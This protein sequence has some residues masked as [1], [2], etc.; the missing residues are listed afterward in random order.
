MTATPY[1]QSGVDATHI[2]NV[3][4]FDPDHPGGELHVPAQRDGGGGS[5]VTDILR[6][7][8][9][10]YGIPVYNQ[11]LHL[12]DSTDS[13]GKNTESIN[14]KIDGR[15]KDTDLI[16]DG[17]TILLIESTL[18]AVPSFK[19]VRF[20]S[21]DDHSWCSKISHS[22]DGN[23]LCMVETNHFDNNVII[24]VYD[25]GTE[26]FVLNYPCDLPMTKELEY[27][28]LSADGKRLLIVVSDVNTPTK[29]WDSTA[30][31][32][33]LETGKV[34]QFDP[35]TN[36]SSACL[37]SNGE[38]LAMA[39]NT[40]DS[41]AVLVYQ[42]DNRGLIYTLHTDTPPFDLLF[43]GDGQWLLTNVCT[44]INVWTETTM[45]VYRLGE[46]TV[47]KHLFTFPVFSPNLTHNG[48]MMVFVSYNNNH[49]LSCEKSGATVFVYD[50]CNIGAEKCSFE[51]PGAQNVQCSLS[52][53]GCLLFVTC[54]YQ[55]ARN[56]NYIVDI[57][58]GE[59]LNQFETNLQSDT[60]VHQ[61]FANDGKSAV[62]VKCNKKEVICE[63]VNG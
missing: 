60:E 13:T 11:T 59:L 32:R 57:N 50:V 51:Y 21:N 26:R 22:A 48:E 38:W 58:T 12:V 31:V 46:A 39:T 14:E 33:Y 29:G 45:S 61:V 34:H 18:W 44:G 36:C 10:R 47:H 1:D 19:T 25:F 30:V 27:V 55:D 16:K 8:Q 40:A 43:S 54:I 56:T 41:H 2:I 49:L 6:S 42:V 62:L 24:S 4:T 23:I 5:V 28:D 35:I 20:E 37:S 52:A 17:S 53:N 3:C 63:T 7:I 15:L 9:T